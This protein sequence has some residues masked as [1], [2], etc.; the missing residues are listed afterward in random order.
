MAHAKELR[1]LQPEE[2]QFVRLADEDRLEEMGNE[3]LGEC[4]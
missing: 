2:A 1:A 3:I 4:P